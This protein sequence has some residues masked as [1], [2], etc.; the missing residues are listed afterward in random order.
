MNDQISIIALPDFQVAAILA[1]LGYTPSFR[2]S[3][4]ATSEICVR[5][6]AQDRSLRLIE[7]VDQGYGAEPPTVEAQPVWRLR[8]P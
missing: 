6:Y 7:I 4:A 1:R 8:K 2:K 3:S 5:S